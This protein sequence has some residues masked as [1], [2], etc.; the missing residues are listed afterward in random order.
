MRHVCLLAA[1]L[2]ACSS[3]GTPATTPGT[4]T[5]TFLTGKYI[6]AFHSCDQ[7]P[8]AS[9]CQGNPSNHY[10]QLAASEDGAAWTKLTGWTQFQGSVPDIIRRGSTLY[11]YNASTTMRKVSVGTG[12]ITTATVSVKTAAGATVQFVDPS[13]ILVTSSNKIVLF[14]LNSTG[15]T[16]D[17]ASCA[18]YPC[19]KT[20]A[21]ATEVDGTDGTQFTLDAGDRVQVTLTGATGSTSASDPDIFADAT[22]FVMLVSQGANV[23]AYRSSTL[24]GSYVAVSGLTNATLSTGA[25]G[26]PAGHYDSATNSYWIY[27]T[28]GGATSPATIKRAVT[29]ML[30]TLS[31]SSFVNVITGTGFGLGSTFTV[32]SPGFMVNQ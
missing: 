12:A 32:E 5:T 18:S 23:L 25:G 7:T 29:S 4:S 6:M 20:F 13:P 31:P 22:G 3:D 8:S 30:T 15:S 26:V 16:G 28:N 10:T 27:V 24:L 2:V 11:I 21:S 19:T 14:F 17:P 1:V 9:N